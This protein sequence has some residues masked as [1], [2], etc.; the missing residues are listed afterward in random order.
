MKNKDLKVFLKD[1]VYG[2][3]W[4]TLSFFV[5]LGLKDAVN[6]SLADIL[7]IEGLVLA[8]IGTLSGISGDPIG[9]GIQS[10]E[11]KH[12]DDVEEINYEITPEERGNMSTTI[13]KDLL[14]STTTAPLVIGGMLAVLINFII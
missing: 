1:I 3:L 2:T 14:F 13:K 9:L 7:F 11:L 12:P 6:F 10:L 4:F 5:A 8:L